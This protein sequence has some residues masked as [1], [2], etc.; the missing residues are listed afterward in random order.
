MHGHIEDLKRK[1]VDYIF[2]PSLTYNIDEKKG[3]NHYNCPVVAYYPEV[4]R[5]NVKMNEGTRFLSPFLNI[6]N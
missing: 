4:I 2:A 1:K 3:D 5:C 6:S